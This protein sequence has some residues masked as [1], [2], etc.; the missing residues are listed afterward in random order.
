MFRVLDDRP[1][2][3]AM[4][5]V[6]RPGPL[7]VRAHVRAPAD[8]TDLTGLR[9]LLTADLLARAA[10]LRG[11]QVLTT[12]AFAGEP[13]GQ[14]AA[15]RA[16]DA[17]GVHPP[18][19]PAAASSGAWPDGP[20]HVHVADD[21]AADRDGR[22]GILIRAAAA[23]LAQD[24]C[25]GDAVA[26]MLGGHDPLAVRFAL[27]S[28]PRQRPTELSAAKLA[29]A[30][31]TLGE[32]RH[33]VA[34]W[35]ESPSRRIPEPVAATMRAAFDNLD[36]VAAL[37]SLSRLAADRAVPPGARFEAFVYTDRVLGLDLPRDIGR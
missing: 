18:A 7:R 26:G 16:A 21:D 33:H 36:T 32:W 22:S 5:S 15:E 14:A 23:R 6:A 4:V 31:R 12:R 8:A 27:M 25:P 19:L 10:E 3:N 17:L 28:V 37:S 20:A 9:V 34:V 1:G 2:S 24:A 11:L 29:D 13:A 35:A 30:A